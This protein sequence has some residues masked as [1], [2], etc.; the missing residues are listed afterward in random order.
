[1]TGE[2][3]LVAVSGRHPASGRAVTGY[4]MHVGRTAGPDTRRPMLDI[5]GRADGAVSADGRV[6][7]CYVHGPFAADDFRAAWLAG[8]R[9]G[10]GRSGLDYEATVE[11][12][13][14]GLA[15][16]LER[17]LDVDALLALAR[18]PRLTPAAAAP[19]PA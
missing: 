11:A 17:H 10:R 4:E 14:D 8:L 16:H 9:Q 13:L 2:K 7:G 6:A 5:G 12:T 3:A 15:D 18:T 19:A 1:M